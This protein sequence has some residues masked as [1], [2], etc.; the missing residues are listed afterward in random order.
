MISTLSLVAIGGALGA[1]LRYLAGVAMLRWFGP[2][3]FPLGIITVNIV[4]SFLMGVF[5]V[6]AAQKGLA[7]YNPLIAVGLLGGFTTFSSF[8]LETLNLFERGAFAL[9]LAYVGA[10]VVLSL[11]AIAC[12]LWAARSFF[13]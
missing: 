6:T 7:H 11:L 2:T 12:G 5:I 8:S 3:E 9:A 10:S 13:A 1:S 4:G